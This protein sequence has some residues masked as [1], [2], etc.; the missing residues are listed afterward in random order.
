MPRRETAERALR[1]AFTIAEPRKPI[2]LGTPVWTETLDE[3]LFKA[4]AAEFL[5]T[6]LFLFFSISAA[7][8]RSPA[9]S[10]VPHAKFCA[11]PTT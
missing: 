2:A 1:K 7:G 11:Y 6:L 10:A 4:C 8:E 3:N 5:G 9:S